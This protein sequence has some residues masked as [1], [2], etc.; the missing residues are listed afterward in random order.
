MGIGPSASGGLCRSLNCTAQV[1]VKERS[2]PSLATEVP[3]SSFGPML[4]R[5]RRG[6][7]GLGGVFRVLQLSVH[8]RK[9][10][11]YPRWTGIHYI[12]S[13][14]G[15]LTFSLVVRYYREVL[16]GEIVQISRHGIKSLSVVPRR[17][18]DPPAFCIFEYVYF[19]RPDSIFEGLKSGKHTDT[20]R[21]VFDVKRLITVRCRTDGLH[22]QA[23]LWP[24]VG[25]RGSNRRRR[26]QHCA[27]VC[28]PC[29]TGLRS[30]GRSSHA[31]L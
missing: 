21:L 12:V 19:A 29:C 24:T 20:V 7:R 3:L 22:R 14:V 2:R 31:V 4:R 25:H 6:H 15:D 8:R 10:S 1:L 13:D 18:G 5:W 30:A 27:G 17:E 16:P 28:D 23:A 9:V 11:F 26:G